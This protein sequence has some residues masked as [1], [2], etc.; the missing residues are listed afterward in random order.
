MQAKNSGWNTSICKNHDPADATGVPV[1]INVVDSNGNYREI[2]EL[3]A[4]Q[5]DSS[6]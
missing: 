1:T 6:V 5:M 3:Q 2:G 4:T